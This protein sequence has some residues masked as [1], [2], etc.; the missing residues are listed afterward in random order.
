MIIVRVVFSL[1]C[2]ENI[3]CKKIEDFEN[4]FFNNLIFLSLEYLK[5]NFISRNFFVDIVRFKNNNYFL[6]GYNLIGLK[7]KIL[8]VWL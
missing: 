4:Y 2:K 7:R 1:L 8:K 6:K 5:N 3:L